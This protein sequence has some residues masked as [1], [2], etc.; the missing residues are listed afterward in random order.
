MISVHLIMAHLFEATEK[1]YQPIMYNYLYG[2]V[3][4]GNGT[5][6]PYNYDSCSL[7]DK[8]NIFN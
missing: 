6:E 5:L 3:K 4:L 1:G 7:C 2:Q 8:H